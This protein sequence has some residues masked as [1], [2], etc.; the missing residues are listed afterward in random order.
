MPL[1]QLTTSSPCPC[2]VLIFNY[3][4]KRIYPKLPFILSST[5]S[6]LREA[7]GELCGK[8][9]KQASQ[10]HR[11]QFLYLRSKRK[12]MS[13][14]QKDLCLMWNQFYTLIFPLRTLKK[15]ISQYF[16]LFNEHEAKRGHCPVTRRSF[17]VL[18]FSQ[19]PCIESYKTILCLLPGFKLN[20]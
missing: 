7:T 19:S 1:P 10:M 13:S 15:I 14:L 16:R 20:T 9:R 2:L 3:K 4:F 8:G 11:S 5:Q 18:A 12:A 17:T 6:I